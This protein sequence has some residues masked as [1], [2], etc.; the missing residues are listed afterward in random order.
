M[1]KYTNQYIIYIFFRCDDTPSS[2][3]CW[4]T[5]NDSPVLMAACGGHVRASMSHSIVYL[6]NCRCVRIDSII[7]TV[8]LLL[9]DW[10]SDTN[11]RKETLERIWKRLVEKF[12]CRR[13]CTHAQKTKCLCFFFN[14]T[15]VNNR[16]YFIKQFEN[17]EQMKIRSENASVYIYSLP[18]TYECLESKNQRKLETKIQ[19]KS[20][21]LQ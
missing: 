21:V 4:S 14:F 3:V 9:I 11:I 12:K 5:N 2:C 16:N 15:Y 20:F 19:N 8:M 18:I 6:N 7:T 17:K 1:I 10:Y 13:I